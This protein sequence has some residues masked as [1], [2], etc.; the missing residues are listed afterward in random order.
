MSCVTSKR[1]QLN[2]STMMLEILNELYTFTFSNY[3]YRIVEFERWSQN[4]SLGY[5]T[6]FFRWIPNSRVL[7][8]LANA[9]RM[10]ISYLKICNSE[11]YS[12]QLERI[13]DNKIQVVPRGLNWT[14][15]TEPCT[16][17]L[18]PASILHLNGGKIGWLYVCWGQG[19]TGWG[20]AIL[21]RAVFTTHSY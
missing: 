5:N 12:E 2:A 16:N 4:A 3:N 9:S 6:I 7:V 20:V 21:I 11:C 15:D 1:G 17:N 19:G 14:H 18:F 10:G 13:E 8:G